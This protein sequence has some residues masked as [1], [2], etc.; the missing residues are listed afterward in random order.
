MAFEFANWRRVTGD[1]IVVRGPVLLYGIEYNGN[2][3][4]PLATVY[5]GLDAVSGQVLCSLAAL[6]DVDN[7]KRFNPPLFCDRG[8]YIDAGGDLDEA[9]FSYRTIDDSPFELEQPD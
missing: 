6:K 4:G 2:A 8:I 3:N 7:N 9:L 1:G 5:E